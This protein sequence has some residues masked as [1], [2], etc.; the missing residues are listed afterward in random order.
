LE[1][2]VVHWHERVSALEGRTVEQGQAISGI[3][4]A[5]VSLE[6]RLDRRLEAIDRRFEALDHRFEALDH[7]L[8]GMDHRFE[9]ID[10]RLTGHDARFDGIDRRF[11]ALDTKVDNR[12]DVLD[13]KLTRLF[14][15]MVGL[16]ITTIVT[17]VVSAFSA[18]VVAS[19]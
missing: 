16:F 7:R 11:T 14:T 17:V 15:W 19:R 6:T 4:E 10:Q 1:G 2:T 18:I 12:F 5:I 9:G 13:A 8:D 3:R